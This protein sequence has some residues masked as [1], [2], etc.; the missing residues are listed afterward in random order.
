MKILKN[1]LIIMGAICLISI[2][3]AALFFKLNPGIGRT[4][5]NIYADYG[6]YVSFAAGD[7]SNPKETKS[8]K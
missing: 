6:D 3:G 2:W 7:L 1:V 8:N 5:Q 4:Q